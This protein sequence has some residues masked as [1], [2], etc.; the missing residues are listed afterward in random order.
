[1]TI[2]MTME[3]PFP[4]DLVE[5]I[6]DAMDVRNNP[7]DGLYVHVVTET[8]DG[9]RVT[10]IWESE[11]KMRIFEGTRLGPAVGK[12]MAEAGMELPEGAAEPQVFSAYD[13]V[14]GTAAG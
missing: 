7:P 8:D 4:R 5:R 10:D 1:M 3:V 14:V 2:L 12:V 9:C 13:L 6:G 11:E